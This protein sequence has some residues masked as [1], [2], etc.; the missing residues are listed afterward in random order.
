MLQEV[1]SQIQGIELYAKLQKMLFVDK[2]EANI[3]RQLNNLYE[4]AEAK[5]AEEQEN[6]QSR[7]E[8]VLGILGILG[9][10][11]VATDLAALLGGVSK[12]DSILVN[13]VAIAMVVVAVLT[14]P[15]WLP[16]AMNLIDR[17][18]HLD[19]RENWRSR[20]RKGSDSK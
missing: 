7:F 5:Q 15:K 10:V 8:A 20:S 1:T 4:I 9:L 14:L 13:I 6:K 12:C 3:Q 2:L 17:Y 16:R 19:A 18:V 11:S